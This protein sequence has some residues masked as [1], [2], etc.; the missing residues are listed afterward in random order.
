MD[1]ADIFFSPKIEQNGESYPQTS[2]KVCIQTLN[3][4]NLHVLMCYANT[5]TYE[6]I[7]GG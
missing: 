1:N 3:F 2:L 4:E 6:S 5:A 7:R